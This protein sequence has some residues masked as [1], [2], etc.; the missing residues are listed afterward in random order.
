M[1]AREAVGP[2]LVAMVGEVLW[3]REMLGVPF[4]L[5][6]V[7][8]IPDLSASAKKTNHTRCGPGWQ[9]VCDIHVCNCLHGGKVPSWDLVGNR[10]PLRQENEDESKKLDRKAVP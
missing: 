5:R 2:E 7:I 9:N 10:S 8:L 1:V 6:L 3:T 4:I